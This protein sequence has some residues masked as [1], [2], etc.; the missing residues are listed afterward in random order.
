MFLCLLVDGCLTTWHSGLMKVPA[1]FAAIRDE[2]DLLDDWE[3]RYRALIEM[4]RALELMSMAFKTEATKV[5]GCSSQVWLHAQRNADGGLHFLGDSD[6]HIVKG[7]VALLFA[8]V[9]DR[10][11]AEIAALD[12]RAELAVLGLDKQ[13]S[14][15]R[16]NGFASMMA[17]VQEMARAAL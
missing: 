3:E 4:G 16:T 9:Q 11:P 5:R 2:F 6:A 13:L 7:L 12:L 1:V 8:L 14:P 17:R 10:P 15:T